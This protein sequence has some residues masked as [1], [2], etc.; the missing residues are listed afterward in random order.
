MILCDVAVIKAKERLDEWNDIGDADLAKQHFH[1]KLGLLKALKA[2]HITKA[3]HAYLQGQQ[4]YL[5]E[6]IQALVNKRKALE[7]DLS[8]KRRAMMAALEPKC[9]AAA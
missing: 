5:E 4:R 3:D 2:K 1:S 6:C 8:M 7:S 9:A